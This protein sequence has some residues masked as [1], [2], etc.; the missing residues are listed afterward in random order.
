MKDCL[1]KYIFNQGFVGFPG[2]GSSHREFRSWNP[3]SET[4][5][6]VVVTTMSIYLEGQVDLV[7]RLTTPITHIV[8]P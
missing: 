5:T 4:Y 8:T 7:S 1:V 3:E 2:F 6:W